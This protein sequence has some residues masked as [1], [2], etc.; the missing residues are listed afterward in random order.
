MSSHCEPHTQSH[1]CCVA[2]VVVSVRLGVHQRKTV[3]I[4]TCAHPLRGSQ[5]A[6]QIHVTHYIVHVSETYAYLANKKKEEKRSLYDIS[7][8]PV[9]QSL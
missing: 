8:L 5:D 9:T 2:T 4:D 3:D 6:I 7:F 1:G